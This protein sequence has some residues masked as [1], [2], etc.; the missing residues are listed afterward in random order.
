MSVFDVSS[1]PERSG[2]VR[3]PEGV[4][5]IVRSDVRSVH[6][7]RSLHIPASVRTIEERAFQ[8]VPIHGELT[9][10]RGSRLTTVEDN[11]FSNSIV[12]PQRIVFP[13]SLREFG[14]NCFLACNFTSV[15]I[16]NDRAVV[17][18]N[19]FFGSQMLT[20]V[21]FTDTPT[22]D[23]IGFNREI[24][25]NAF[26]FCNALTR[27]DA[28]GVKRV[29]DEAFVGNPDD[30][31]I[32]HARFVHCLHFGEHVFTGKRITRLEIGKRSITFAELALD[33]AEITNVY[34]NNM[35]TPDTVY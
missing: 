29:D 31:D 9:F 1:L 3:V 20:E 26:A 10:D 22:T 13:T 24:H 6:V 19:A 30:P 25:V 28:T 5:R 15:E 12:H 27:I 17:G 16:T 14:E 32:T 2:D 11:A 35:Y 7:I 34:Y 8:N 21:I 18:E 4:T 33:G 23:N